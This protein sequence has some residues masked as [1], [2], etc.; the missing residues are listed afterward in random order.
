MNI[1][2]FTKILGDIDSRYILEAA[3]EDIKMTKKFRRAKLFAAAAACVCLICLVAAGW[4][5]FD[6]KNYLKDYDADPSYMLRDRMITS[7]GEGRYFGVIMCRNGFRLMGSDGSVGENAYNI[8]DVQ[9][10]DHTD[11]TVCKALGWTEITGLSV[12]DGRLYWTARPKG[13]SA[14]E[15]PD[16]V[17]I[18]SAN[19]DGSDIQVVREVPGEVF[20]DTMYDKYIRAHRG[21]MYFIGVKK[22]ETVVDREKMSSYQKNPDEQYVLNVY[23]EE[24]KENGT[25]EKIFSLDYENG[26]YYTSTSQFYANN[27]YIMLKST[28]VENSEDFRF[29]V[30]RI[31]LKNHGSKLIFKTD[32]YDISDWW[33]DGSEYLYYIETDSESKKMSLIRCSLNSGKPEKMFELPSADIGKVINGKVVCIDVSTEEKKVYV[34]DFDGNEVELDI[35]GLTEQVRREYGYAGISFCGADNENVIMQMCDDECFALVPLDGSEPKLIIASCFS[36]P[37]FKRIWGDEG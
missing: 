32:K 33:F 24:L 20:S 18:M 17:N 14:A 29:E 34:S 5:L 23:A 19:P 8:C 15:V 3:E 35:S 36:D 6:S 1:P 10:C 21:Y 28:D 26:R 4:T 27:L 37:E 22:P 7:D 25:S 11:N 30:Y 12:Y 16:A 2:K 31:D 13:V 9:G